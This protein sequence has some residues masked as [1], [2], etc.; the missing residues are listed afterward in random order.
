MKGNDWKRR[1]EDLESSLWMISLPLSGTI[2]SAQATLM[3]SISFNLHPIKRQLDVHIR[4]SFCIWRDF[5]HPPNLDSRFTW[6]ATLLPPPPFAALF[7][8]YD[9]FFNAAPKILFVQF[10]ILDFVVYIK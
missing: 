9:L 4:R 5:P 10:I 2:L 6:Y 8:S 1:L 3:S 7:K